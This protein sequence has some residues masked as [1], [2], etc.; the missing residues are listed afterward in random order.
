MPIQGGVGLGPRNHQPRAGREY[1]IDRPPCRTNPRP[2]VHL[3][4]LLAGIKHF[5]VPNLTYWRYVSNPGFAKWAGVAR[6]PAQTDVFWRKVAAG[7]GEDVIL[8]LGSYSWKPPSS[9]PRAKSSAQGAPLRPA[10]GSGCEFTVEANPEGVLLRPVRRAPQTA[11]RE[12]FGMR[13]RPGRTPLS[14]KQIEAAMARATKRE[15]E[16]GRD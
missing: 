13:K 8:L 16:R 10:V 15:H 9:Q 1:R 5:Y 3:R 6:T 11:L 7:F 4:C 2:E 12:V 14:D